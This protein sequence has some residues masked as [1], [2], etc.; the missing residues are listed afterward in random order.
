[1]LTK[2]ALNELLTSFKADLS[3]YG[4]VPETMILYGSYAKGNV[5]KYSDVDLAV[6][7]KQFSGNS[8]ED[9][10]NV[11][12]VLKNYRQFHVKFYPKD[13]DEDNFDPFIHEIK[14]TGI[15]IL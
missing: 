4:Y 8:F 3:A 2:R 13:A 11:K 15:K 1:M 12:P 7:S 14:R 9:F 6:W 10:E 5:H